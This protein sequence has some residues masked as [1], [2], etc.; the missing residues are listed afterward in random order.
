MVRFFYFCLIFFLMITLLSGCKTV[1][2]SRTMENEENNK[3]SSPE[4]SGSAL[5]ETESN[6]VSE[7]DAN[8]AEPTAYP[9]FTPSPAAGLSVTV[10][11][12]PTPVLRR[13]R[14]PNQSQGQV[15]PRIRRK[16]LLS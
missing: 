12:V 8:K 16:P 6:A 11:R 15:L 14:L 13:L 7:T 2:V 5:P 1:T 10:T 3:V 9:E 4:T